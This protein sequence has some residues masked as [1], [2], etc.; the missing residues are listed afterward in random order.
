M[1]ATVDS[2]MADDRPEKQRM[3]ELW[4]DRVAEASP[5]TDRE[6]LFLTLAGADG[7]D[8]QALV[9][10]DLIKL[11]ETGA[12]STE[13]AGKVVA[14]ES[15]EEAF[16]KLSKRFQGLR[17]LNTRIEDL[18]RREHP[19]NWPAGADQE[20]FRAR[21]VN[22]DFDRPLDVTVRNSQLV[23]PQIMWIKKIATIHAHKAPTN[24]CLLLTCQGQIQWPIEVETRVKALLADN[25]Q[26]S[27]EFSKVAEK[28]LGTDTF[29][30][31]R[32]C[33]DDLTLSELP[34]KTQQRILMA[35]VPKKL[36]RELSGS[37]WSIITRNNVRYGGTKKRAP[38]VSFV[39][40][41]R[42]DQRSSAEPDAVYLES[43]LNSVSEP[44]EIDSKG[45]IKLLS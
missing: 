22:F 13:D 10:A 21:V 32:D 28:L 20:L 25:F 9:D 30:G 33:S 42:W 4:V 6:P 15:R 17:V 3:R 29:D 39:F 5:P 19:F 43:L 7:R 23:F 2:A 31:I 38:M 8:V 11:T 36:C 40:E 18:L 41:F 45:S 44:S 34:Y 12:I 27:E 1:P 35:V 14:V 26:R 37:G 24:W 16:L